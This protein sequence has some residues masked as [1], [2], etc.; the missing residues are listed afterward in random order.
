M[1][2]RRAEAFS[3]G[4]FAVA[5]TVLVFGLLP[6]GVGRRLD[7]ALLHAWPQYLAYLVSFLTIGIMWLNHHALMGSLR[8]V[9]RSLLVI[10]LFLL[11]GVVAV[12]WPTTLVADHLNG[13]AAAGGRAAAIV[14]GA[15]LFVV[16]GTYAVMWLYIGRN[17]AKIARDPDRPPTR[18]K[19]AAFM[20]GLG[21]YA[22]GAV[23]AIVSPGAALTVYGLVAIYYLFEHQPR[24]P[25]RPD[26]HA[27]VSSTTS[28]GVEGASA[29]E[30]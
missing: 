7:H 27:G 23:V 28:Q 14:Y 4:V 2:T 5:I 12:P 20:V 17:A 16:L 26:P 30:T 13:A 18:L 22:I 24:Q 3:D 1:E 15:V 9:D 10:N 8:V 25:A 6:I 11:M 29:D 19:S 21:G